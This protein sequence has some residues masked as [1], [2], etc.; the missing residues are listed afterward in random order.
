[1]LSVP[2]VCRSGHAETQR[3]MSTQW[4][5]P[6][7]GRLGTCCTAR[8]AG[9]GVQHTSDA[10]AWTPCSVKTRF[11]ISGSTELGS[12]SGTSIMLKPATATRIRTIWFSGA[13]CVQQFAGGVCGVAHCM[14]CKRHAVLSIALQR[15][16]LCVLAQQWVLPR[17][18]VG[19]EW[20]MC[21]NGAT[22]HTGTTL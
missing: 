3:R 14:H 22:T 17:I 21:C 5:R 9:H 2:D 15:R 11:V 19:A 7:D 20:H 12:S 10:A 1:M 18:S 8:R 13:P 4:P 6:A 16:L